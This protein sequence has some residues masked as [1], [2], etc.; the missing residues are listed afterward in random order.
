MT[1]T[2]HYNDARAAWL[3]AADHNRARL[4]FAPV[5][6]APLQEVEDLVNPTA[7]QREG[8]LVSDRPGHIVK[9]LGGPGRSVGQHESHKERAAEQF[10]GSVCE[11]LSKARS[12]GKLGRLYVIAEPA[13]LGLLRQHMDDATK[14]LI[15]AEIGKDVTK[16]S[17]AELRDLLPH[18]L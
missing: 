10:A 3:V 12:D 9:G 17:A 1:R 13:F 5:P 7:L 15:V 6:T 18:Q 8:E 14:A 4:F 11:H 16:R 2:A